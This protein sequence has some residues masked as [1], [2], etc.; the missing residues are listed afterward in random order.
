MTISVEVPAAS[1]SCEQKWRMSW[2][3]RQGIPL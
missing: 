3:L 1:A 2:S